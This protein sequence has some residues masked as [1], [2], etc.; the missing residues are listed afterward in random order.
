M[1]TPHADRPPRLLLII[2]VENVVRTCRDLRA[3]FRPERIRELAVQH[4]EIAFGFALANVFALSPGDREAIT[5]TAFP[6]VHCQRLR[7]GNGGKDTVDE[8]VAD[9]IRRFLG[10]GAIDGVVIVTDDRNFIP[11]MMGVLDKGRRLIRIA[12]R[13]N[14]ELDRIGEV[15]YLPLHTEGDASTA[16]T[17]SR[18][19]NAEAFIEG[20]HELVGK[21]SASER[22]HAI[23][24]LGLRTPLPFRLL[25]AYLRR[26]YGGRRGEWK[27]SFP[28]LLDELSDVILPD[29][30]AHVNTDDL[31]AFLTALIEIGV[32][33]RVETPMPVGRMRRGY[34]PNWKHP[35]CAHAIAD[36]RDQEPRWLQRRSD[37]N[38]RRDRQDVGPPV[39][40]GAPTELDSKRSGDPPRE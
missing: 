24:M 25:R 16:P 3:P 22:D 32:I 7:D 11:I 14:T 40:D 6:L 2:D 10:S 13:R 1:P 9:L 37:G 23:T 4:G 38:G 21:G 8:H 31:S 29:D 27:V 35:F 26:R 5:G 15:L 17:S 30:C 20:L 18:R 34:Y 12:V 19:W 28:T 39:N 36:I 33:T